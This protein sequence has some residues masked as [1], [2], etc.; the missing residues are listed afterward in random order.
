[1]QDYVFYDT[2]IL[3]T[4]TS[5][6]KPTSFRSFFISLQDQNILHPSLSP[7]VLSNPLLFLEIIGLGKIQRL[8]DFKKIEEV[9]RYQL[10]VKANS[11]DQDFLE[12]MHLNISSILDASPL[13]TI[14]NLN[15]EL[16]KREEFN[17]EWWRS[18]VAPMF[19]EGLKADADLSALKNALAMELL[20]DVNYENFLSRKDLIKFNNLFFGYVFFCLNEGIL[21]P[22]VRRA[23]KYFSRPLRKIT[24]ESIQMRSG[25][26]Y[27][28]SYF[29]H[30]ALFGYLSGSIKQKVKVFTCESKEKVESRIKIYNSLFQRIKSLSPYDKGLDIE[31]GYIYYV[32]KLSG[33]II[34]RTNVHSM[35]EVF[36]NDVIDS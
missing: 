14:E 6:E 4:F 34:D 18:E 10:L 20:Q 28:D 26:E 25:E 27:A 7:F 16:N 31:C 35:L 9:M 21:F 12:E 3:S 19:G 22:F 36:K 11:F 24:T 30:Y 15:N 5:K 8:I 13:L 32:D 23:T 2:S 17:N 29:C 1:M 33:A